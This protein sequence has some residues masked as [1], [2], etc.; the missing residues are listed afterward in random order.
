[1]PNTVSYDGFSCASG[2]PIYFD[3][4]SLPIKNTYRIEFSCTSRIPDSSFSFNPSGF[5]YT[6]SNKNFQ[7][8]TT[9]FAAN[10]YTLYNSSSNIIKLSI[11]NNN[12]VEIY[13]DYTAVKCGN[14]SDDP[15]QPTATPTQ[16][17]TATPT[18][19]ASPTVTPTATPAATVTRTNSVTPTPSVTQTP[20]MTP[21]LGF[22]ASFD[23][24]LQDVGACGQVL[25][26]GIANGRIG[27][28]YNYRF[29]TDMLGVDMNI[30]NPT[31]VITIANNPT[32][33]DTTLFMGVKCRN[34]S[35]KFGLSNGSARVESVAFFRCGQCS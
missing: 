27:Q 11:Y 7:L 35:L 24:L 16:S 26:R 2:I 23:T 29:S 31:G 30:G 22:S 8:A 32:Y 9:F 6:P 21:P 25:V 12:N 10:K 15:I 18:A 5:Y 28:T 4:I 1:M 14:L 33:I 19:T 20:S 13:R 17:P 34:Y 3:G